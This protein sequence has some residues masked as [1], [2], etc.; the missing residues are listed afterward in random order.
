MEGLQRAIAFIEH[1]L[2]EM[3]GKPEKKS[4]ER[5]TE[6]SSGQAQI[7][8]RGRG[9]RVSSSIASGEPGNK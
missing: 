2:P 1:F 3:K 5:K 9:V 4:K 6:P 8:R 7:S